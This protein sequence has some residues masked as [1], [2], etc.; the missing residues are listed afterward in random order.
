MHRSRISMAILAA[1]SSGALAAPVVEEVVV[2][3]QRKSEL[4]QDVPLAVSAVSGEALERARVDNVAD[5][6]RV[7]PALT[8]VPNQ[9]GGRSL[10][11]F[12][13]RGMSQQSLNIL[14]D[15]SVSVY[16]GDI[17]VA[18]VQGVNGSIFDVAAAEVLRGPQGTLFGRNATGGAVTIRPNTPTHE[19]AGRMAFTA[20][21]H[22]TTNMEG[23]LNVPISDTLSAR[24]ALK[25][26][27]DDGFVYDEL[28][29]RNIDDT[30]NFAGRLSVLFE[31]SDQL[32]SLTTYDYFDEDS[33]GTP[34]FIRYANDN[35]TFNTPATR[36]AMGYRAANE[37]LAEQ[38]ARGIHK[39]ANGTPVFTRVRTSTAV[40]STSYTFDNGITIK[41]IIGYRGVTSHDYNDM[42]GT[43]NSWFPQERY[44]SGE[45]FSEELQ[46]FGSS[47]NFEWIAGLYYFDEKGR[48][49][50]KSAALAPD[51]GPVEYGSVHGYSQQ[52][53]SVTDVEGFNTSYAAYFQG[54]YDLTDALTLTAGLR[55]TRDERE[56]VVRNRTASAC[57]F[58]MDEDNNPATPE[59][60]PGLANCQLSVDKSFSEPTYNISLEYQLG[61]SS[62][63]Y[64]AHRK[65]YRSG[66]FGARATT[67]EG[68]KQTFDPEV[69]KD[70]EVGYKADW[71]FGGSMLRTNIAAFYADYEDIQRILTNP[72]FAPVQAVT[73][74]AGK[75]RIQGVELDLLYR[76]WASLELTAAYSY[77][78]AEYKEFITPTGDDISDFPLARAPEHTYT[79]GARY[80]LPFS[81]LGDIS[82]GGTYY[83]MDE[84]NGNDAYA[85]GF[86]DVE[87]HSLLNMDVRWE[88]VMGTGIDLSLFATNLLNEE[89]SSLVI[90]LAGLGFVGHTPGA[91]RKYGMTVSYSF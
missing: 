17:A 82:I 13:I 34:V 86:T 7:V 16:L 50:G 11:S 76:P 35:G 87:S 6:S 20:G 5:L 90:D 72:N 27:K 1:L 32:S 23:M 26:Q 21:N 48:D 56:M 64:I 33:G 67:E 4:I 54:S 15:Q 58:S 36:A 14:D 83:Y 52:R 29:R 65:G 24:I 59:T 40:N 45:Q 47:A 10:P 2:T 8:I 91:P 37:L 55:Y 85:P 57:R 43:S 38:R 63:A 77:T 18:R 69:V 12:A 39:V 62:L 60:V 53:Y 19:L 79:L 30:D 3:A 78:D 28:L 89:Y 51:P 81:Q 42:D 74:N 49:Q 44:F 70:V 41:N 75:A 73:S 88:R 71:H 84:Y 61:A 68:F 66:G 80:W 22:G 46:V 9:G 25:K 31:P